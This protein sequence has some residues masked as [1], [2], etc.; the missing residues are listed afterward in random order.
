LKT[1]EIDE[2]L[3]EMRLSNASKADEKAAAVMQRLRKK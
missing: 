1:D 2:K 3:G